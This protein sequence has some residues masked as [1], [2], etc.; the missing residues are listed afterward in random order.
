MNYTIAN[1]YN[2]ATDT[3]LSVPGS[4][5]FFGATTG[6]CAFVWTSYAEKRGV[7][8]EQTVVRFFENMTWIDT[9]FPKDRETA[10]RLTLQWVKEDHSE[11]LLG[12]H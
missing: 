7:D 10:E 12:W 1:T 11:L 3:A 9:W 5:E 4:Y 8:Y 6:R 2:E